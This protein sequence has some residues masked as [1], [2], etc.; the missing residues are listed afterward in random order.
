M[1]LQ[2]LQQLFDALVAQLLHG[3]RERL[4]LHPALGVPFAQRADAVVLLG[5][6]GQVEVA[7]ERA[8]HGHGPLDLPSGDH[9]GDHVGRDLTPARGD[10]GLAQ[11]F[12]VGQ[13]V[14]AALLGQHLAEQFAEQPHIVA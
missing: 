5:E 9:F 10:D 7:R 2:A 3:V 11:S 12:D 14:V 1:Q 8:G 13:Q 4:A 6:V